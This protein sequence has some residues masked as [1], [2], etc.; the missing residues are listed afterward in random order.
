MPNVIPGQVANRRR[1]Y[2]HFA[3][4]VVMAACLII[5][6][7]CIGILGYHYLAGFEWIDALLNASMILSGMGPMGELNSNGAKLFASA[8]ALFSGLVLVTATGIILS[9]M[10]HRVLHK[11]HIEQKGEK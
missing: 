5:L 4:A 6:S 1:F 11:F 8:Y 2:H 7:L 10:F 3:R 9:P